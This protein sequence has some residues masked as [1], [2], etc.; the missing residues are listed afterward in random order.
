MQQQFTRLPEITKNLIIINVLMFLASISLGDMVYQNLIIY[1]IENDNFQPYQLI[2]AFFMHASMTHLFFNMFALFMFGAIVEQTL[3][4]KRFL[5]LYLSAGF[6]GNLLYI[7]FNY[8]QVQQLTSGLSADQIAW[9]TGQLESI[10]RNLFVPEM[11]QIQRVWFTPALGASGATY[12]ILFTF[13]VLYPNKIIYLLIPPIPLK[14]KYMVI[15]LAAM[16][17]YLHVSDAQTGIAHSVHLSGAAI[18][19][20]IVW[21]WRKQG[22]KF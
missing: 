1:Y 4:P 3:G 5:F 16:E 2:T 7:L 19:V 17:F 14:A 15:G 6:G 8:V 10:P 18:A 13:A 21:I 11:E 22:A 20:G 12:G 9:A